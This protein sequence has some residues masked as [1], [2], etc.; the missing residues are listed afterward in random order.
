MITSLFGAVGGNDFVGDSLASSQAIS[1]A[2]QRNWMSAFSDENGLYL[3]INQFASIIAVGAFLFFIVIWTREMV[4]N[5]L[6][7]AVD[8]LSWLILV[9]ILLWNNGQLLSS[10]TLGIH[11]L[12]ET[13]TQQV[14][15][16]Q[17]GKLT[18]QDALQDVVLTADAK[19]TIRALYGECQAK[20]GKAQI[21]C[22]D[23]TT[24]QAQKIVEQ[25]EKGWGKGTLNGLRRWWDNVLKI[26]E[27]LKK[28]SG[29]PEAIANID[30]FVLLHS[31]IISTTNTAQQ[32]AARQI[33][34]AWQW[35][36]ANLMEAALLMTG[37]TGPIA[38]AGS[39]L[40]I[41]VRPLWA[42]LIGLF[43]LGMV[44]FYYNVI[45][46]L[47]ATVIVKAE[48]QHESDFGFVVLISILAPILAVAL[49][50]GGGLAVY[51]ALAHGALQIIATT[52]NVAR[53]ATSFGLRLK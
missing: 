38:V 30:P 22:F 41:G 21:E 24:D 44:K 40:P 43:S 36:F 15:T 39:V 46:G 12:I 13:E 23:K 33:L 16:I 53:E 28:E 34:K 52:W 42:W 20:T 49:A 27:S 8:R 18:L 50:T 45:V 14:L 10:L 26:R 6:L 48:A 47:I 31:S 1:E 17:L 9:L 4:T 5:G 35:A 29:E 3:S 2:W 19:N 37:L 51:R 11:R 7:P 32:A 25:Y